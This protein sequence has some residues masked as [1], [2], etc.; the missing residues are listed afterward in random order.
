[1]GQPA[2]IVSEN[3]YRFQPW[4]TKRRGDIFVYGGMESITHCDVVVL[5][6]LWNWTVDYLL[7]YAK[8][9]HPD[10]DRKT[11]DCSVV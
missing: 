10:R 7:I 2:R 1:M 3:G 9:A 11:S 8:R 6:Q 5:K 4:P